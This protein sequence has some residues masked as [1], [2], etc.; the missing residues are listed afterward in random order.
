MLEFVA[1][2]FGN[3]GHL[4]NAAS[5]FSRTHRTI[6]DFKGEKVS[7]VGRYFGRWLP[8]GA[9]AVVRPGTERYDLLH[10]GVVST[11]LLPFDTQYAVKVHEVTN[12]YIAAKILTACAGPI[13]MNIDKFNALPPDIQKVFLEAG[14]DAELIVGSEIAPRWFG[15][16]QEAWKQRGIVTIDF[17]DTEVAKWTTKLEDIPAEWAAE[18]EGQGYPGWKIVQRWQEITT[19]MGFKWSRKWG[20]KK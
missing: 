11:D 3:P 6:E 8:P 16:V 13:L 10:T 17:P 20:L 9:T 4:F 18:V 12:Y 7:L 5:A 2:S 19:E 14:K 1:E 15:K